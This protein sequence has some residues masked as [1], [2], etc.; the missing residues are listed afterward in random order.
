MTT[1][2]IMQ[3]AKACRM[4]LT[5]ATGQQKNDMLLAMGDALVA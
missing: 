2:E 4:Q 5:Q 3:Q 1:L